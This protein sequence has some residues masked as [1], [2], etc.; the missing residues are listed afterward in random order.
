MMEDHQ[1]DRVPKDLT[2]ERSHSKPNFMENIDR[3]S[4]RVCAA[5]PIGF[6]VGASYGTLSGAP[7]LPSSLAAGASCSMLAT[8]CFGSERFFNAIMPRP[9][10]WFEG[11]EDLVSHALGGTL[12]G[13]VVGWLY[14]GKPLS[15][16]LLFTPLMIGIAFFERGLKKKR[17][18]RIEYLISQIEK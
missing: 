7:I 16:A 9:L 14:R 13:S 4:S 2:R 3:V 17:L 10:P 18:D 12:G 8:A 15:G 6:F 1:P 11:K 5:F